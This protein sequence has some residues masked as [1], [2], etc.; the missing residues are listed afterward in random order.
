MSTPEPNSSPKDKKDASTSRS[1]SPHPNRKNSTRRIPHLT[2]GYESDTWKPKDP[3]IKDHPRAIAVQAGMEATATVNE[4]VAQ[5]M[6]RKRKGAENEA[7]A[8][9]G[10]ENSGRT[11]SGV[12]GFDEAEGSILG[13]AGK[14]KYV[15]G[16]EDPKPKDSHS[17]DEADG[18]EDDDD[19]TVTG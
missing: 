3:N 16:Q 7:A 14:E 12:T 19:K 9:M 13:T 15:K 10:D 11:K 2:S 6:E 5:T 18:D 17:D 8:G 4:S 1:P